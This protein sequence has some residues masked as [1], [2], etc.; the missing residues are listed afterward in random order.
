MDVGLRALVA[1][2]EAALDGRRATIVE[3]RRTAKS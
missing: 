2:G 3:A 1:R